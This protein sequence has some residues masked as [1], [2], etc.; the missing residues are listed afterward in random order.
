MVALEET[1]KKHNIH[2][3]YTTSSS[4]HGHV[5]FSFGFSFNTSSTSSFDEWLIGS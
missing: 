2:I 4:S 1:M 3:D 5:L